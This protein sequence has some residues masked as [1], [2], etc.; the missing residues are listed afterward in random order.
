[1]SNDK[2][3]SLEIRE[4]ESVNMGMKDS[5]LYFER[6]KVSGMMDDI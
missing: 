4:H 1:M 5:I 3:H 2:Q 6:E